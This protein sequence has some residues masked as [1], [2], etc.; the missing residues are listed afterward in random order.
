MNLLLLAPTLFF[1]SDIIQTLNELGFIVRVIVFSYLVYWFY[2]TFRDAQ[3]IFGLSIV[4]TAYLLFVHSLS[5]TTLLI[6]FFVFV[7]FGS[8]LQMILLFGLLPILG[9]TFTGS[10]YAKLE[11]SEANQER[12]MELQQKM[13]EGRELSQE[14]AQLMQ[15]QAAMGGMQDQMNVSGRRQAMM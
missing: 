13:R 9:Y 11:Q 6:L 8:Q 3:T 5:V 14:E 10:Q 12:V 7:V 1:I 4:V 15:G 2:I